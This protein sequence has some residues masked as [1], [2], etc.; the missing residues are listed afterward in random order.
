[1]SIQCTGQ[2]GFAITRLIQ[3]SQQNYL[4]DVPKADV[5]FREQSEQLLVRQKK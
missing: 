3:Q 2:K 1:M 4:K 5:Q